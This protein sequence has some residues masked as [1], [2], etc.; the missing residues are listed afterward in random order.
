MPAKHRLTVNLD[1]QEYTQLVAL[2]ER[3]HVSLAWL[4]REAVRQFLEH[5]HDQDLQLP[6]NLS[7]TRPGGANA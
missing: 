5:H 7:T 3:H 2:S 1:K 4:G 6:L